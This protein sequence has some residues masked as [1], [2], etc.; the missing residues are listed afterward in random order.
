MKTLVGA[1]LLVLFAS[2]AEAISIDGC[3]PYI[4]TF[5]VADGGILTVTIVKIDSKA[6]TPYTEQLANP[7]TGKEAEAV[8]KRGAV[9]F[10]GHVDKKSGRLFVHWDSLKGATP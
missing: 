3:K 5:S 8:V 2:A 7:V 6:V 9:Q 10:E 4:G 1:V